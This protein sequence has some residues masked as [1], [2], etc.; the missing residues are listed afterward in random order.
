M[1]GA[2]TRGNHHR[3]CAGGTRQTSSS[4]RGQSCRT[5]QERG[6]IPSLCCRGPRIFGDT[7]TL[8]VHGGRRGALRTRCGLGDGLV[9]RAMNP[10]RDEGAGAVQQVWVRDNTAWQ[11]VLF[12]FTGRWTRTRAGEP[13]L[14]EPHQELRPLVRLTG[15]P[16]AAAGLRLRL[17]RARRELPGS[18]RA[19]I[20]PRPALPPLADAGGRWRDRA[21]R[22]CD[23]QVLGGGEA[24][25]GGDGCVGA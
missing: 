1:D 16:A 13:P 7:E 2:R 21:L 12:W 22:R 17:R 23:R 19:A 14:V 8:L 3:H 11:Y 15:C 9:P 6:G 10:C 25:R 18:A 4:R 5:W 24:S 20:S